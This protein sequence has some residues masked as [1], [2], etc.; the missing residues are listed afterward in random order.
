[1]NKILRCAKL[2]KNSANNDVRVKIEQPSGMPRLSAKASPITVIDLEADQTAAAAYDFTNKVMAEG[3][4]PGTYG[5]VKGFLDPI[6]L[7]LV[8]LTRNHFRAKALQGYSLGNSLIIEGYRDEAIA[9]Q[10]L[11]LPVD[12][13]LALSCKKYI[14]DS[15]ISYR[16]SF[17]NSEAAKAI[18]ATFHLFGEPDEIALQVSELLHEGLFRCADPDDRGNSFLLHPSIILV[19]RHIF[20]GRNTALDGSLFTP[21][22]KPTIAFACTVVQSILEQWLD[23][24][25]ALKIAFITEKYHTEHQ[26]HL[27][28]IE[29]FALHPEWSAVWALISEELV[30]KVIPANPESTNM[31]LTDYGSMAALP[32]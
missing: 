19:L 14:S 18:I 9:E 1:M 11:D 28:A 26:K 22:P 30:H 4:A 3:P 7:A 15:F 16:G 12:P 25:G 24:K 20:H 17:R 6:A 32:F 31:V 2:E 13:E 21:M 10:H 8:N 23:G 5:H 29:T 27:R